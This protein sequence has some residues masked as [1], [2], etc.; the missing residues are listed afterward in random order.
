[1]SVRLLAL[2]A[3]TLLAFPLA[4]AAGQD[5]KPPQPPADEDA[6]VVKLLTDLVKNKEASLEKRANACETLG[7][8]GARA[9][10]SVPA[11]AAF[12]DEIN[13]GDLYSS[14]VA[15]YIYTRERFVLLGKVVDGLGN[16]GPDAEPAVG[17][18]G[19]VVGTH[20]KLADS[21]LESSV[22]ARS[23]AAQALVKIGSPKGIEPLSR[24]VSVDP[25][26]AVRLACVKVL[27]DLA[28]AKDFPKRDEV[29]ALLRVVVDTDEDMG[30]R[31]E[32]K[33]ILDALA[34][35]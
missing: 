25:T 10:A 4:L 24:A 9:K 35:Q 21:A 17:S 22:Q 29:K 15:D 32:A 23:K 16:L 26:P 2:A 11:M 31:K 33:N 20:V 8:H 1:M 30:V 5:P 18:I 28:N 13:K 19:K 34:K 3:C 27:G 14:S 7:K 12:L 6:V